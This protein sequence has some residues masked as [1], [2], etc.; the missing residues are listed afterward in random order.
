M[1]TESLTLNGEDIKAVPVVRNLGI[2][3]D[4]RLNLESHIAN[5]QK[6]CYYYLN[7]IKKIRKYLSKDV[8]K[9][10]VHALVVPRIDYCNSIYVNLPQCATD[11]LQRIMRSAARLIARPERNASVTEICRQLH[12]LPIP[13]RAEFKVLTL[14]YKAMH[15]EAPT[16]ISDMLLQYQPKRSLRS[17]N[18]NQLCIRKT[19]VR[20]GKRA[21]SICGP[22]L[23]NQLP[24]DIRDSPSFSMFKRK[25]KT[26]LFRKAYC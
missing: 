16:Y 24:L 3:M 23:W 2:Y 6:A 9:S 8:T 12:W 13:Q 17:T 10:I 5:V 4:N 14:V 25:L 7:W 22:E 11:R 18:S 1:S 19:R 15:G 20:Y 21:F 26:Y